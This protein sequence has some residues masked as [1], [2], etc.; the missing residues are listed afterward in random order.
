[1]RKYFLVF[2]L[3]VLSA[4]VLVSCNK[5][6]EKPKSFF[7]DDTSSY[8]IDANYQVK[9]DDDLSFG[10]SL[11]IDLNGNDLDLN[12]KAF[13]VNTSS[14]DKIEISNG[15]IKNGSITI[16]GSRSKIIFSN[17]TIDSS[18]ENVTFNGAVVFNNVTCNNVTV[19]GGSLSLNGVTSEQAHTYEDMTKVNNIYVTEEALYEVINVDGYSVVGN[20][21]AKESSQ[22]NVSG[23][24]ANVVILADGVFL[25]VNNFANVGTVYAYGAYNV[26]EYKTKAN[27]NAS[28]ATND[29]YKTLMEYNASFDKRDDAS[30]PMEYKIKEIH[31]LCTSGMEDDDSTKTYVTYSIGTGADLVTINTVKLHRYSSDSLVL[32]KNYLFG[33]LV[34]YTCEECGSHVRELK[35]CDYNVTDCENFLEVLM[36]YA[37][38]F[39]VDFAIDKDMSVNIGEVTYTISKGFVHLLSDNGNMGGAIVYNGKIGEDQ[40]TYRVYVNNSKAYFLGQR[41]YE[42]T[43]TKALVTKITDVKEYDAYDTLVNVFASKLNMEA[44]ELK[45]ML[46]QYFNYF[47]LGMSVIETTLVNGDDIVNLVESAILKALG[48]VF[49]EEALAK[50]E[51]EKII[52]DYDE[53]TQVYTLNLSNV[54]KLFE[55]SVKDFIDYMYGENTTDN[56]VDFLVNDLPTLTVAEF[57]DYV[58]KFAKMNKVD[59]DKLFETIN[60]FVTIISGQEFDIYEFITEFANVK[61]SSKTI[62]MVPAVKDVL[63]YLTQENLDEITS[64]SLDKLFDEYITYI[65]G[66]GEMNYHE[67]KNAINKYIA[68]YDLSFT[69]GEYDEVTSFDFAM[70]DTTKDYVVNPESYN[71]YTRSEYALLETSYA[72]D[73]IVEKFSFEI[74]DD[75]KTQESKKLIDL[76][77][78]QNNGKYDID[79]DTYDMLSDCHVTLWFDNTDS[80]NEAGELKISIENDELF[81]SYYKDIHNV[82]QIINVSIA[83]YTEQGEL[84]TEGEEPVRDTTNLLRYTNYEGV[85]TLDIDPFEAAIIHGERANGVG[86]LNIEYDSY[87]INLYD[88]EVKKEFNIKANDSFTEEGKEPQDYISDEFDVCYQVLADHNNL[89]VN[90]DGNTVNDKYEVKQVI[91]FNIDADIYTNNG[92]ELDLIATYEMINTMSATVS[93]DY[94]ENDEV[95]SL[96]VDVLVDTSD[97]YDNNFKEAKVD[98]VNNE[99]GFV[100]DA[101]YDV[102]YSD[103]DED[104]KYYSLVGFSLHA[105]DTDKQALIAS[106]SNKYLEDGETSG[107]FVDAGFRQENDHAVLFATYELKE[108]NSTENVSEEINGSIEV[109]GSNVLVLFTYVDDRL[110]KESKHEYDSYAFS[111]EFKDGMVEEIDFKYSQYIKRYDKDSSDYITDPSHTGDFLFNVKR[112]DL[113]FGGYY[114]NILIDTEKFY[115]SIVENEVVEENRIDTDINVSL[116]SNPENPNHSS[117]LLKLTYDE[118]Y[119]TYMSEGKEVGV[120]LR[121]FY[122]KAADG[123]SHTSLG[124]LD[125]FYDHDIEIFHIY[126][127]LENNLVTLYFDYDNYSYN[128]STMALYGIP[129]DPND[130]SKGYDPDSIL[131]KSQFDLAAQKEVYE[132]F[133]L[134]YRPLTKHE[135]TNVTFNKNELTVNNS[136]Y[137]Y[138][139][140]NYTLPIE[141]LAAYFNGEESLVVP[142][143]DN[144]II[145]DFDFN[146]ELLVFTHCVPSKFNIA[147]SAGK[148]ANLYDEF[149]INLN[150][151]FDGNTPKTMDG[152]VE[153]NHY[154]YSIYLGFENQTRAEN[155]LGYF[156]TLDFVNND[157]SIELDIFGGT[158]SYEDDSKKYEYDIDYVGR[159][160]IVNFIQK[161][162]YSFDFTF[163]YDKATTEYVADFGQLHGIAKKSNT[164]DSANPGSG[165]N[166]ISARDIEKDLEHRVSLVK[167]YGDSNSMTYEMN[168]TDNDHAADRHS[169]GLGFDKYR[170]IFER[171]FIEDECLYNTQDSAFDKLK[172]SVEWNTVDGVTTVHM[173]IR[174]FDQVIYDENGP[175]NNNLIL[176]LYFEITN[177]VDED[178]NLEKYGLH[179]YYDTN[180]VND[181]YVDLNGGT[182]RFDLF[183]IQFTDSEELTELLIENIYN[184]TDTFEYNNVNVKVTKDNGI[185][186]CYLLLQTEYQSFDIN[187]LNVN[188]MEGEVTFEIP[189]FGLYNNALTFNGGISLTLGFNDGFKALLNVYDMFTVGLTVDSE[190]RVDVQYDLSMFDLGALGIFAD[191]YSDRSLESAEDVLG[192][193]L[194]EFKDLVPNDIQ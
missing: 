36:L 100:F 42:D 44:S 176:D 145:D 129:N 160:Q 85:E 159:D 74:R 192:Y 15:T 188:D 121:D 34:E 13:T 106:F 104:Q 87:V 156:G 40:R 158:K 1:M 141:E 152:E 50:L 14:E 178:T 134:S 17:V 41:T 3:L 45:D 6:E 79:F 7:N 91:D 110:V 92:Y 30:V 94:K 112:S 117:E 167:I 19:N 153:Y 88:S 161:I 66:L 86:T 68:K 62:E 120:E 140:C 95:Q 29:S 190:S 27:V 2:L 170:Y 133:E 11:S 57:A 37:P 60:Q 90:Y 18:I 148:P 181:Q 97:E 32:H 12:G 164:Y 185:Y 179:I 154:N 174:D 61:L 111:Y 187:F 81:A 144:Y 126:E 96:N 123:S 9:E 84:I 63:D 20:I 183:N 166:L 71:T 151:E 43:E 175:V 16:L 21:Y 108:N 165:S 149:I 5:K 125:Y 67:I 80:N 46:N 65:P 138:E 48:L 128:L 182:T 155:A 162:Y 186:R 76:T 107:M 101:S 191:I 118:T 130:L 75:G 115:L 64:N 69:L 4:F 23:T 180:L 52:F 102:N 93:F 131:T 8:V 177:L 113:A 135:S 38:D 89:E 136:Y 77:M 124:N 150:Y 147:E 35:E 139:D 26:V 28:Y 109:T 146:S 163:T 33:D 137:D 83:Q 56:V 173:Q 53:E 51:I 168:L 78:D 99:E 22:I 119:T 116:V 132:H 172:E 72:N 171:L 82:E 193:S 105:E 194:E 114:Y 98:Y 55:Y 31:N 127:E 73:G 39:N 49:D 24:V 157:D 25:T 143:G 10:A 184:L 70:Y 59:S 47:Q 189:R 142:F 58:V 169:I 103:K 122:S 54:T